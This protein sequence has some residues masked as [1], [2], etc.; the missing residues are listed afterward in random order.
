MEKGL[1]QL[2]LKGREEKERTIMRA[3]ERE[4]ERHR[5]R[6]KLE[7]PNKNEAKGY[8]FIATLQGGSKEM[9]GKEK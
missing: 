3:N 5:Q 4:T 1:P 8:Q 2:G 9:N 7:S 6:E